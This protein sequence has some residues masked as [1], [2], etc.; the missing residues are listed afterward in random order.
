MQKFQWIRCWYSNWVAYLSQI[1]P[2]PPSN[3]GQDGSKENNR[4]SFRKTIENNTAK[5]CSKVFISMVHCKSSS[6]RTLPFVS[7]PYDDRGLAC[8]VPQGSVL[9]SMCTWESHWKALD[10]LSLWRRWYA[11]LCLSA[12]QFMGGWNMLILSSNHVPVT[13]NYGWRLT[14]WSLMATKPSFLS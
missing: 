11:N 2:F 12:L 9:H 14:N 8:S 7:K 13:L 3:K 10:V 1:N 6:C 5:K 4:I